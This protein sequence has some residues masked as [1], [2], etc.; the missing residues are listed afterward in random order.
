MV[1]VDPVLLTITLVMVVVLILGNVYF[2]AY[3]S[4]HADSMFG[5]STAV[6]AVLVSNNTSFS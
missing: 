6:K 2:V 3:Y 5:S 1:F 4:H